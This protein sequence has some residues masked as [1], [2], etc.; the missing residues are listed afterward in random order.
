MHITFLGATETVTGSKYLIEEN[1]KNFLVDCGLFQGLKELRLRNWSRFPLNPAKIEAVILTHAHIDHSG[2]LPVL[3]NGGFKGD[4]YCTSA[5]YDLCKILLPDSAKLQE[6]EAEYANKKGYSKHKPALPLYTVDDAEKALKYFN[7]IP[8]HKEVEL[9]KDLRF[10]LIPSG[11]IIGSAFVKLRNHKIS[12]LFSGDL[13]RQED[14]IMKTPEVIKHADYLVLESTY[15][16]R[17]H[18]AT[19]PLGEMEKIIN[20]TKKNN[21]VVII[22][23]FSVGR[24]QEV[25]YSI[26]LLKKQ[27][28]IKDIPV[29]LNSPMS[30]SATDIYCKHHNEH[31]LSSNQC[32]DMCSTATYITSV[33]ESKALNNKTGPMIIISASGMATGGRVLHHIMRFAPD[34]NN[35]IL[36]TG[37]QA[38][39]TRGDRL[40]KGE[41][42][43]KMF[44]QYIPINSKVYIIESF[45]AHADQAEILNWVKN[46][47]SPPKMTFITHG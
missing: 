36:F 25:L 9:L 46:F 24:T 21:G 8:Y 44:G 1:N 38:A 42:I 3:V 20:E 15:G 19:N 40:I 37:Y 41:K 26:C 32:E 28:K 4:I 16:D 5:T 30:I 10:E 18:D 6:E 35:A 47:S 33:E 14:L 27:K 11:H 39:G 7:V 12:V 43:L 29:Y 45:S 2:Y 13:G 17:N 34:P 22:P 31:K 23:A